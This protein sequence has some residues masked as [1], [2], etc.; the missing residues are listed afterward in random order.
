MDAAL[1]FGSWFDMA[2]SSPFGQFRR[3]QKGKSCAERTR[4]TA[5]EKKLFQRLVSPFQH[6]TKSSQRRPGSHRVAGNLKMRRIRKCKTSAMQRY[7]GPGAQSARAREAGLDRDL[8]DGRIS[9]AVG[10]GQVVRRAAD[11]LLDHDARL[12]KIIEENAVPACADGAR[13]GIFAGG[14]VHR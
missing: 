14:E 3:T 10:P 11:L 13:A 8:I 12:R 1:D 6:F 7:V 4:A 9:E 2:V 5:R